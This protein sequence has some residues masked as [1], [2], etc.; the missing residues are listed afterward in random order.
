MSRIINLLPKE[1]QQELKYQ[2]IA[3]G[4]VKVWWISIGTFLI[5]V[6][7]QLATKI[8]LEHQASQ[9][10]GSIEQF[11][12]QVNKQDNAA[13]KVKITAINNSIG[14]A[15][16]L[17]DESPK[18]SN[19]FKAFSDLPP[20]AVNITSFVVDSK[21]KSI[22]ISGRAPT[23]ESVIELYNNILGDSK[24]FSG[25]DYPLE[26]VAKPI[27]NNFHFTFSVLDEVLK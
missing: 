24:H 21:N 7:A 12:Q 19:V 10:A 23:R 5:V 8:Y 4:M 15:K 11:Q 25:I 18:W 22:A 6:C 17:R 26:N 27:N 2:A 14:D 1:K 13:I 3:S 16:T 9:L 20:Q